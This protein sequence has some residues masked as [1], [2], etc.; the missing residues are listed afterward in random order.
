MET[1]PHHHPL[2]KTWE[3]RR[4]QFNQMSDNGGHGGTV[5]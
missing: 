3:G 1:V 5:V 4:S 2:E